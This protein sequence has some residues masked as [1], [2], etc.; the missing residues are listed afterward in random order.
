MSDTGSAGKPGILVLA[1]SCAD[2]IFTG[3]KNIPA[4]GQEEYGDGLHIRAGGGANTAYMLAKLGTPA[5]MLTNIGA[6]FFGDFI[7][8]VLTKAGV[9]LSRAKKT[10]NTPVTAV[11]TVGGDRAFASYGGNGFDLGNNEIT[12]AVNGRGIV[13]SYLYYS[14]RFG[15]PRICA[16]QGAHLSLDAG[17]GFFP[18]GDELK[19]Q[20]EGVW[21]FK[22]NRDEA[23]ELTGKHTPEEMLNILSQLCPNVMITLGADGCAAIMDG[24]VFHAKAPRVR[25]VDTTGSGDAF[26][27]GWLS[28]CADGLNGQML[29][30]RACA[31]GSYCASLIGGTDPG[32]SREAVLELAQGGMYL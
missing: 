12:E 17:W 28:G 3:L 1:E 5:A 30:D 9:D 6:D 32:F 25:L 2:I 10:P 23:R 7:T 14:A 29:I 13:H 26:A 11:M 31:A 19:K 24:V 4:L 20:L 16:E 18:K 8:G 22:L 27:A 21:A 15:L